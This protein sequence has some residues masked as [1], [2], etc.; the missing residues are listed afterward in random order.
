[1][2]I[3]F[4]TV[5]IKDMNGNGLYVDL[6]RALRD[7]G[8]N[9]FVICPIERRHNESTSIKIEESI[10]FL[11]VKTGNIT[12]TNFIEKG[13]ST[14]LVE[15]KFISAINTYYEDITFDLVLYTTPPVTFES[16]I[17]HVKK[18]N[19]CKSYLI[20]KDIFPQNAVDLEVMKKNSV[21]YK[22]FKY[23]ERRLYE[24]SDHIGC[25]SIRN[26]KYVTQ[27]N[28]KID[29]KNVELFPNSILPRDLRS[30]KSDVISLRKKFGIPENSVLF[31]YG[32]NIGRPQGIDF[33]KEVI[34]KVDERDDCFFMIFGSGTE[35]NNI[36]N[37]IN[38]SGK[39]NVHINKGISNDE[40]WEFL[41]CCDVGLIF[42]DSRFTVPNTPARLTY[43]MESALPILAATD[44]NTDIDEILR[45][46]NCGL[47][48]E[49][50]DIDEFY[51]KVDLLIN[52]ADYR[53]QLGH[54]GRM[55][56]ESNFHID[57]NCNILMNHLKIGEEK[58]V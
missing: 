1:M 23:K 18:R 5:A 42:L 11:R 40:Y 55:Y 39:K 14:V 16:V 2:N 53:K 19:N 13:I 32:G 9:I 34:I 6:L 10:T 17:R 30:R 43:Y 31:V 12:K 8:N 25:T 48:V 27:H 47:W 21:I 22:Y 33:L 49:S 20:L 51:S 58:N 15:S 38:K 36:E 4:L 45:D 44:K 50:G 3:L 41:S 7:Q 56:M 46:A 57:M 24:I 54:N 28:P 37:F 26:I 35:Y 29:S 52:N